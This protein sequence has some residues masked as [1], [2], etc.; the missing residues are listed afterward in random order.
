[1]NNTVK[2]LAALALVSTNAYAD[3]VCLIPKDC[4]IISSE[5]STGGGE[6]ALYIM[7]VDC[8]TTDGTV[9]K[10][11]STE[12]SAGGLLGMGRLAMPR[13]IVFKK[14]DRDNLECDY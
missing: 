6:K 8:K 14:D 10:Y 11:L 1:M 13:K 3:G 2:A 5:F 12:V 4:E 9:I 7:E